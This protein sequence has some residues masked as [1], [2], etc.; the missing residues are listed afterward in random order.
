MFTQCYDL[1]FGRRTT[2]PK[3]FKA[4]NPSDGDSTYET[5]PGA[6]PAQASQYL[7]FALSQL[8]G[9]NGHHKF[10]NIC[11]QL[12]RRR[13][14]T[15]IIPATGPVS[16]G[17]DQ[18]ADFETYRTGEVVP[19]A[20]K[21]AFFAGVA[22]E[23]VVFACSIE[24]NTQRKI[25]EDLEAT[26]QFPEKVERLVFF[27]N[28]DV[29][30][31]RRH[32]LQ[33]LAAE[34]Y[35]LALEVFDSRAIIGFLADP[36]L[37]WI[38]QEFLSIPSDFVLSLPKASHQW[39]EDILSK[40]ISPS[41]LMTRDFF[42][43]KDAVRFATHEPA[44]R[45][46]LPVLLTKIRFFR[47][48]PSAR[49]QRKA[50]YEDFVASLRGLE[51]V[52]GL[53]ADLN[54][55]FSAVAPSEETSEITDAAVLVS[56]SLGAKARGLL[57]VRVEV[58][59]DWR[60]RVLVRI[61]LLLKEPGISP[62][63]RCSLLST[64]GLLLI[65]DWIEEP[66]DRTD[67]FAPAGLDG[68]KAIAVWRKMI[69]EV[70]NA[71]MFPLETFGKLLSGVTGQLKDTAEFSNLIRETDKLLAERFGK[72]KLAEQ[73]FDRAA[74]YQKAGKLLE[75]IDALHQAHIESFTEETARDSVTFSIFLAKMYSEVGLHFA[76][77]CYALGAAF[78]ALK[79]E[80]DSLKRLC[81]RGLA[82]AAS[83]DHAS[84]ASMEF[85]L[86]AKAFL[87][88]SHEFSMVGSEQTKQ[89]ER[90]RIDFY[91]L[92]LTRAASYFSQAL[93]SYLK[94]TVLKFFGSDEIYEETSSRLD[95]FF[96][97]G[98]FDRL[99]EKAVEEGIMPPFSDSGPIRLV[100]WEQLAIRWFVKWPNDFQIAQ[101]AE[102]FCAALQILLADLRKTELSI[103]PSDVHISLELHDGDLHIEDIPDNEKVSMS[104][105]LPRGSSE[106]NNASDSSAIAQ[107]VA[108]TAL[109]MVSGLSR[110]QFMEAYG[111]RLKAGLLAKLTPYTGY[112]R[113]FREFYGEEDF[114][115]HYSHSL[116]IELP[117]GM[118]IMRTD[119]ELSGPS[120]THREYSRKDSE[121]L[122]HRRYKLSAGQLKY[123][124][125]RLLND[126]SFLD[127]VKEL[128]QEGWKDW[129]ILQATASVRLNYVIGTTVPRGSGL[130]EFKRIGKS[131]FERDE[132]ESDPTPPTNLFTASELK[133]A[134]KITQVS[135]LTGLG[136]HCWQRT[137]NFDAI[138]RFLQRFN[139]WTDD[140][141][142][143]KIFP[144]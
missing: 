29:P 56:Y 122:I 46:D 5:R 99:V 49:I 3:N 78:A 118:T 135:T 95:D 34:T 89:F 71:P 16:A 136:F 81:Y 51:V 54:D 115:Q 27:S 116:P 41:Q 97:D 79:L 80:D 9:E 132:Q 124:L 63:R 113:L 73:A 101:S 109:M 68:A 111:R 82:E 100:G 61:G 7:L 84:G 37:F 32:R 52:R 103:L 8:A 17:G 20:L 58:I 139:Y 69:K 104:I 76:S 4:T 92:I 15:N 105:L 39:Y 102:S 127:A 42:S 137:P 40:E 130:D 25:K 108:T 143:S 93:Q 114:A 57:D 1:V 12:A 141:M 26:A 13:I 98:G 67:A 90:S 43:L 28:W 14:Y 66:P 10:E 19:M 36:E 106:K 53:E 125:P 142:H 23:K 62:G 38:A 47:Q 129:H 75:A 24:K 22:D 44:H 138:D 144:D 31:G 128:R 48:H 87:L 70:R 35:G 131:L 30:V 65:H 2:M 83:S 88:I 11:F 120:G 85:F 91:C 140:V 77:K 74:S 112:D 59:R 55:Y 6:S 119:A 107:A 50:F 21:T 33:K 60:R 64:Q 18:G 110:E 86:T 94:D 117:R 96:S 134:L 133:R 126:S 72:H 45:S 123:T 121:R